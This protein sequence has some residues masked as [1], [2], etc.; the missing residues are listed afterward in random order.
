MNYNFRLADL[1][2]CLGTSLQIVPS[3]NLPLATK[4][5][6]GRLVIVNLQ[7]TKHDKKAN[8]KINSYVDF[9]M[10]LLCECLN[11]KIL[12][13]TEPLVLLKSVYTR[14]DE[15]ELSVVIKDNTLICTKPV[16]EKDVRIVTDSDLGQ[17]I[18]G[19]SENHSSVMK[20]ENQSILHSSG[21][22]LIENQ[23][24]KLDEVVKNENLS[25]ESR[26]SQTFNECLLNVEV[27]NELTRSEFGHDDKDTRKNESSHTEVSEHVPSSGTTMIQNSSGSDCLKRKLE[28]NTCV[29]STDT[30]P[31][32]R[33]NQTLVPSST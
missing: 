1:S 16:V 18:R 10:K 32:K 15:A 20:M 23:P 28:I 24:I 26:S 2:L 12:D 17:E 7:P 19:N 8:M 5:N 27:K 22:H 25:E 29:E 11:I 3:G 13:F 6:G 14:S 33:P 31:V 4:R 9:V 30:S 21:N